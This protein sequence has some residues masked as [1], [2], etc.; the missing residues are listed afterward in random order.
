[1][2]MSEDNFEITEESVKMLVFLS[3]E[4]FLSLDKYKVM[5]I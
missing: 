4:N 1:M 3:L 5:F 2:S